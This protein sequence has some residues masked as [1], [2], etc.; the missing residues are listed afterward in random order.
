MYLNDV[1]L[2]APEGYRLGR[3]DY[4]RGVCRHV[5]MA[6]GQPDLTCEGAWEDAAQERAA[7]EAF[8]AAHA[9]KPA[10]VDAAG[11]TEPPPAKLKPASKAQSAPG[12]RDTAR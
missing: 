9:P 2:Y 12:K 5:F 4:E 11:P 10:R 7:L 8:R 3:S 6:A 1:G